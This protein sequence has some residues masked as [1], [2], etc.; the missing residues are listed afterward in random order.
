M[1]ISEIAMTD[2]RFSAR[3]AYE[4]G[5][6]QGALLR[7]AVAALL[8]LP[9]FL[10]CNRTPLAGLCLAGFALAVAAGRFRGLDYGD[11]T[12]AGAIAGVA[13]CLVPALVRFFDPALCSATMAGVPW[14]CAVGG[15]AAGAIL[16]MRGQKLT[17][18]AFWISALTVL[19]FAASLGC[20]PAGAMG[21]AGLC[22][23]VLAG[24][25]PA[26]ALRKAA[27]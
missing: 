22:A 5:R 9:A 18:L 11:G 21:F 12:R 7:G 27:G 19:G 24:G 6:L 4:M 16:G 25:V 2:L 14:P 17:A 15:I 13:P 8:A 26:L 20:L 3:R 1:T 10:V 23:G